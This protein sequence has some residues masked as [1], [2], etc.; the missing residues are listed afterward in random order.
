M[1]RDARLFI[2]LG[3]VLGLVGAAPGEEHRLKDLNWMLGSWRHE[4][5]TTTTQETW[6]KLGRTV[7]QGRGMVIG[8]ADNKIRSAE[9]LL[10]VEM[11]GEVFY[12]AKVKHNPM[13]VPFKLTDRS[14]GLA[15]FE[16]QDHSFPKRLEYRMQPSGEIKVLVG[17]G[18]DKSFELLL[19]P[20]A[21][22]KL[23]DESNSQKDDSRSSS[24]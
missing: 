7:F 13:P 6:G 20:M 17:D 22:E 9:D 11:Q 23:D 5:E 12:L 8:T 14:D 4:G 21:L 18:K 10:L 15:V 19:K 24:G 16:N 3:I 1:L 2:I